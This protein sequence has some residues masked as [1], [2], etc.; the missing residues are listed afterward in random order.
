MWYVEVF[1]GSACTI[2]FPEPALP[3]SSERETGIIENHQILGAD[4]KDRSFWQRDWRVYLKNCAC[5]LLETLSSRF[6]TNLVISYL[7][8]WWCGSGHFFFFFLH[9]HLLRNR[10]RPLSSALQIHRKYK[11][12]HGLIC[13]CYLCNHLRFVLCKK[14]N[15][16]KLGK[17]IN[18]NKE[19]ER[20]K[21]DNLTKR[22]KAATSLP[23]VKQAKKKIDFKGVSNKLQLSVLIKW[24]F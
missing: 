15:S 19:E 7:C 8:T 5:A 21:R 18:K 9:S 2:S 24:I 1:I 14:N 20:T 17:K 22:G 13:T 11:S 12:D 16:K 6:R 10:N 4:Q 3:L 23:L